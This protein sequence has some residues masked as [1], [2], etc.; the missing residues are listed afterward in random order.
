M[1]VYGLTLALTLANPNLAIDVQSRICHLLEITE[2]YRNPNDSDRNSGDIRST[3]DR[4]PIDIRSD[5]DRTLAVSMERY[6]FG[7]FSSG[8][9]VFLGRFV[10]D[11]VL[12]SD[13]LGM[14]KASTYRFVD[15]LIHGDKSSA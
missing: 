14:W 10:F 5:S 13:G 9:Q 7:R 2:L 1:F 11:S 8:T 15:S 3:P 12:T 6:D 4:I